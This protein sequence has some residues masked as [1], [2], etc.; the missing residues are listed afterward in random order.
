MTLSRPSDAFLSSIASVPMVFYQVGSLLRY[1]GE[2]RR[3]GG[4]QKGTLASL[5]EI[6]WLV[7]SSIDD[8]MKAGILKADCLVVLATLGRPG[9]D[10][11]SSD[12]EN[13]YMIDA[14]RMMA[15]L[16]IVK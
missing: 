6:I 16:D 2:G 8:W 9:Q 10:N 11:G 4:K 14:E 7:A 12:K 1:V 5:V 13:E 3:R 15:V